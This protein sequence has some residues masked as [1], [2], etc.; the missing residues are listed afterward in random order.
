MS[1]FDFFFLKKKLLVLD[2][3]ENLDRE[4]TPEDDEKN[5]PEDEVLTVSDDFPIDFFIAFFRLINFNSF[6]KGFFFL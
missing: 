2:R 4:D 5:D 3:N 6:L 1:S